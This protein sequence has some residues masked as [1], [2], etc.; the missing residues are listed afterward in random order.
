[1]GAKDSL[2]GRLLGNADEYSAEQVAQTVSLL[3]EHAITHHASDIHIEPAGEYATVRYR[4]D[5]S[6]RSMHKL[7]MA[8]LPSLAQHLKTNAHLQAGETATPQEGSFQTVVGTEAYRVQ[9]ST[10]P[11]VGGEKIVLHITP[12]FNEVQP[13]ESLGLWG[14]AL[15]HVRTTLSRPHGLT[16]V[17]APKR[18]GKSTTLYSLLG[19][20]YTPTANVATIEDPIKHELHGI[21]QTQ[22]RPR[23]GVSFTDAL[24]AV[25]HQDPNIIMLSNMPD[26]ATGELAVQAATTGHMVLAGMAADN[27][28]RA[29]LQLRSLEVQPFLLASGMRAS[30]GERLARRLCE[31]CRERYMVSDEQR[32][33][34][35]QSFG[36]PRGLRASLHTWEQQALRD[37][38]GTASFLHT[39]PTGITHMWRANPD[40][41]AECG[42]SGFSGRI[43][44]FEVMIISDHIRNILL[45]RPT[46]SAMESTAFKE[47]FIPLHIDGLIKAL[48]GETTPEEILK[49]CPPSYAL[50]RPA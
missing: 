5:G 9:M 29:V 3:L 1:M 12:Q 27:A 36:L 23:S 43:A 30:I 16:L 45:G 33:S 15:K 49:A 2:I 4:I 19:A 22:V 28:A 39:T 6:L 21:S 47:G 13:L 14:D 25:M 10:L 32:A 40:G 20:L 18:S 31:H 11:V 41:C 48:R 42:Y 8:A 34:L 7:P 35:E 50:P 38:V 37:G 44:L 26:Q 46:I 17:A 24:H